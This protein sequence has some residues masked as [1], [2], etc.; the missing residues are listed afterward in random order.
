MIP[1]RPIIIVSTI[2]LKFG[3]PHDLVAMSDEPGWKHITLAGTI[4]T[5]PDKG[6]PVR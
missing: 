6:K 3:C 4:S 1:S 5:T 2:P